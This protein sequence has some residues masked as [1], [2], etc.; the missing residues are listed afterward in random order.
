[1][2]SEEKSYEIR[3]SSSPRVLSLRRSARSI[4]VLTPYSFSV[5]GNK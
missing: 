2:K 4:M 5:R 3:T 1:M